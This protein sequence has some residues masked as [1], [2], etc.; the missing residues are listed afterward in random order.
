MSESS[1]QARR[2]DLPSGE[3]HPRVSERG[4]IVRRLIG[5]LVLL[6]WIGL[7]VMLF[8]PGAGEVA[9]EVG[10]KCPRS[11]GGPSERC[12]ALDIVLVVVFASPLLLLIGL[13]SVAPRLIAQRPGDDR[14]RSS[15]RR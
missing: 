8:A 13:A 3:R 14:R 9:D 1:N 12:E 2:T 4:K 15:R 10:K 7:I 6:V 11:M 5:F